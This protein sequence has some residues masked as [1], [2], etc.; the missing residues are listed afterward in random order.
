[1]WGQIDPSERTLGRRREL[2]PLLRSCPLTC[3]A[4]LGFAVAS[5]ITVVEG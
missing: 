3:R 1:M 2:G 4:W 5:S